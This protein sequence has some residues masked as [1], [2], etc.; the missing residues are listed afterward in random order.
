[1]NCEYFLPVCGLLFHFI[2]GVFH[3]MKVFKFDK[4]RFITFFPFMLYA[5]NNL[6]EMPSRSQR[7][8]LCFLLEVLPF[9]F[10]CMVHFELTFVYGVR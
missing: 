6:S 4:V 2:S 8:L 10:R 5:F 1:M 3:Q 7:F 9:M